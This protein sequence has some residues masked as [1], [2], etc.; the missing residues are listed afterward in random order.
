VVSFNGGC[1]REGLRTAVLERIPFTAVLG[2]FRVESKAGS[3]RSSVMGRARLRGG[4]CSGA[5]WGST[6]LCR[7]LNFNCEVQPRWI[8]SNKVRTLDCA[9]LGD[10]PVRSPVGTYPALPGPSTAGGQA[11]PPSTALGYT[12][13]FPWR[14]RDRNALGGGRP[15]GSAE[16]VEEMHR[17]AAVARSHPTLAYWPRVARCHRWNRSGS[18]S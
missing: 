5:R 10:R 8:C 2:R 16:P 11:I 12:A 1:F 3:S 7:G 17:R 15:G 14:G 13:R 9:P 4:R 18:S 6:E